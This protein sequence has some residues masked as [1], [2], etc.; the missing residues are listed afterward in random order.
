LQKGQVA[1][2]DGGRHDNPRDARTPVVLPHHRKI[3]VHQILKSPRLAVSTLIPVCGFSGWD[4]SDPERV[5]IDG[6]VHD[7]SLDQHIRRLGHE[8]RLARTHGAGDQEQAVRSR[9]CHSVQ[10]APM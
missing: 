1:S 6:R 4:E 2:V 8:R 3:A 5:E 10:P 9:F 7:P